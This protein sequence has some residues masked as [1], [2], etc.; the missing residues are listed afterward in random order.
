[1]GN[2]I[3][4]NCNSCNWNISG[5]TGVGMNS[6]TSLE[7]GYSRLPKSIQKKLERLNQNE[8]KKIG[9]ARF[10]RTIVK[11]EACHQIGFR[12][13]TTVNAYTSEG[14]TNLTTNFRCNRCGKKVVELSDE[15][16]SKLTCPECHN[17]TVS[18]SN[19]GI[20]D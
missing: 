15:D 3:K 14:A 2:L 8:D 18:I 19:W 10:N 13:K 1:M 7:T 17:N 12:T 4:L 11:C 5:S 9:T 16:D 20:W 6:F